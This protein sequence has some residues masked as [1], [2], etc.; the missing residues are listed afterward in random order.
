[1]GWDMEILLV[2]L[3]KI[4]NISE[5]ERDKDNNEFAYGLLFTKGRLQERRSNLHSSLNQFSLQEN[6]VLSS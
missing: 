3:K 2:I 1:M 5:T 6:I 4:G